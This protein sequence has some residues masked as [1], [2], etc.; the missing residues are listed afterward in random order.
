VEPEEIY[1]PGVQTVAMYIQDGCER[2]PRSPSRSSEGGREVRSQWHCQGP[3]G[4]PV[5][6]MT[7]CMPVMWDHTHREPFQLILM[8]TF[9]ANTIS[10]GGGVR[11]YSAWNFPPALHF[12]LL[13]CHRSF[14]AILRDP[15]CWRA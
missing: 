7:A 10:V 13:L 3:A 6:A 2:N 5:Q 9:D 1:G 11:L 15:V 8:C 14:L 4:G 12:S